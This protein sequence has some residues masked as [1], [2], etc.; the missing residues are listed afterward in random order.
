MLVRSLPLQ[1]CR[2]SRLQRCLKC[3]SLLP[4][5]AWHQRLNTAER[6]KLRRAFEKSYSGVVLCASTLPGLG[7]LQCVQAASKSWEWLGWKRILSEEHVGQTRERKRGNQ[8]LDVVD[9]LAHA[10]GLVHDELDVDLGVSA[11]RVEKLLSVCSHAYCM[12]GAGH[13]SSWTLYSLY[14]QAFMALYTKKPPKGFR[15]PN[16]Q[17]AEEADKTAMCAVFELFEGDAFATIVTDRGMLRSLLVRH[18]CRRCPTNLC[19]TSRACP[20]PLP[21]RSTRSGRIWAR[22][23][24]RHLPRR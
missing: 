21:R 5:G 19:L 16:I 8:S 9:L 3:I 12:C 17:E 7:F 13:L 1:A 18:V 20:L 10:A 4:F 6:D 2:P 14:I 11:Y 22:R 23:A 24:C 15:A